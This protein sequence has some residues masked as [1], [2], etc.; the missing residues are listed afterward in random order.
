MQD[1]EGPAIPGGA[2]EMAGRAGPA[3]HATGAK[4]T[5][6]LAGAAFLAPRIPQTLRDL[7]ANSRTQ[8]TLLP[9]TLIFFCVQ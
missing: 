7:S 8:S 1:D 5:P 4:A 6:L 3:G 2:G 9:L